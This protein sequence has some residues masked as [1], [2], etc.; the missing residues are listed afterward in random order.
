MN[1][2]V[3]SLVALI[4]AIALSMTTRINVGVASIVFAWIVGV[5]VGHLSVETVMRG[6]P[7]GEASAAIPGRS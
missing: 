1:A 6:F 2:A 7:S 5:Y 3:A 4:V